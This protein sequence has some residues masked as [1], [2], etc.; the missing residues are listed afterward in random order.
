MIHKITFDKWYDYFIVFILLIKLIY[1][2]LVIIH[3]YQKIKGK[4]GSPFDK[5]IVITKDNIEIIFI[6]SMSILLIYLFYPY[7]IKRPII[8]EQTRLLL[9]LYGFIILFTMDIK[10]FIDETKIINFI[11]KTFNL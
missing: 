5:K 11:K 10:K 8:D 2:I 1:L 6:A 7:H 4:E 9:F 3:I